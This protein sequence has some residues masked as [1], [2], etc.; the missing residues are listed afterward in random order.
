MRGVFLTLAVVLLGTAVWAMPAAAAAPTDIELVGDAQAQPYQSWV[1]ASRVPTPPGQVNLVLG[2]CPGGPA[3]AAGCA[4]PSERTIWLGVEGRNRVTLLHELGHLFDEYVL[5]AA[6]RR[7]F[8][9]II[10]RR[11]AWEGPAAIDPPH[12]QF[13]EAYALCAR[14]PRLRA[15]RLGMYGYVATPA[16]HR[17]VCAVIRDAAARRP[18]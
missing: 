4:N 14:H 7:R 2:A 1:A 5:E 10:G 6:D 12:E 15:T 9:A 8:Q 11:G 18:S 17:A 16:R 13:A 3:W